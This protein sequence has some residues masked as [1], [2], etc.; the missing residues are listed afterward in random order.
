VQ[1]TN[2]FG[3]STFFTRSPMKVSDDKRPVKRVP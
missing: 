3:I 1:V 2:S